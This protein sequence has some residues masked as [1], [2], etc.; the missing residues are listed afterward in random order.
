LTRKKYHQL[1]D[2]FAAGKPIMELLVRA[3]AALHIPEQIQQVLAP[4]ISTT[5]AAP[6]S[7]ILKGVEAPL[8]AVAP[9]TAAPSAPRDELVAPQT[10]AVSSAR[11]STV[12]A[13][14]SAI[15]ITFPGGK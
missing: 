13:S 5:A 4:T 6:T 1:K 15:H 7:L 9:T 12:G 14:A 10:M 8:T 3:R 2:D 11:E